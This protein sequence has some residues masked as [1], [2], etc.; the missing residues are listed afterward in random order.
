MKMPN[1]SG[2]SAIVAA[3]VLSYSAPGWAEQRT[4][5]RGE[6]M[7]SE[8]ARVFPEAALLKEDAAEQQYWITNGKTRFWLA[9]PAAGKKL[10]DL[11]FVCVF[12]GRGGSGRANN[13]SGEGIPGK[14]RRGMLQAG[15]ALLCAECSSNAWGD[16]ESTAATV[17]ALE[18]CRKQGVKLPEKVDLLGFSMGGLGAL[19]FAAR[20]PAMVRKVVDIFG[21]TDLDDYYNRGFY[22]AMLGKIPEAERRDRSPCA[23]KERYKNMEFLLV[24]GDRDAT[25]DISYSKRFLELMQKQ[26]TPCRLVVVPGIG[27]S[28]DI[29]EKSGTAILEFLAK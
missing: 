13:L 28:N 17:A 25:V 5:G 26:N 16:P 6:A 3:A 19:M 12:S 14:F 10:S 29:L 22:R 21:I 2:I 8:I 23:K 27:H 24:H 15:F 7:K 9:V 4:D 1:C 18:Y 11:H 20:E